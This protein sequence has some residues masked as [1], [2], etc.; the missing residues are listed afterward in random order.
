[1]AK[2][3]PLTI[4]AMLNLMEAG[5]GRVKAIHNAARVGTTVCQLAMTARKLD[6]WPTQAEYAAD[7]KISDRKAQLEWALFRRAFPGEESPDRVAEWLN[8]QIGRRVEKETSAL[9]APAPP[10]LVPAGI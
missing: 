5:D 9:T 10:D 8:N 6:H 2:E 4:V 3:L 1:M 7:W